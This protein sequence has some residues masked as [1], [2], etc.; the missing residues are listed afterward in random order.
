MPWDAVNYEGQDRLG[1]IEKYVGDMA[2]GGLHAPI[3]NRSWGLGDSI[4]AGTYQQMQGQNPHAWACV[5][6]DG[7][8]YLKGTSNLAGATSVTTLTNGKLAE[9]IANA[10]QIDHCLVLLG[11]N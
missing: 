10:S 6:S 8:M 7:K 2:T 11:P 9:V 4:I 1:H 3:G 5:L